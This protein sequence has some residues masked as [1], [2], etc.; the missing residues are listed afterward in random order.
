MLKKCTACLSLLFLLPSCAAQ[1][2]VF[3]SDPPGAQITVDGEI[4]GETPCEYEYKAGAE[5]KY[6]IAVHKESYQSVE[7]NITTDSVDK[8]SRNKWLVAGLIWSPL[9]LG[10]MFTRKLKDSYHFILTDFRTKKFHKAIYTG[11]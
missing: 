8:E 4:I 2:T 1:K 5:K 11:N 3:F 9:W 7:D 10:T 6:R